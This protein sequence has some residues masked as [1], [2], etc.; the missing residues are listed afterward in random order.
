NE[1]L[2]QLVIHEFRHVAQ[3]QQATQGFSKL[4]YW[5][6]GENILSGLTYTLLPE[7]FWEGDAVTME[8]ALTSS[9]RGRIPAFNR[10]FLTNTLENKRF[11]YN[12]QYLGSFRDYVPNHYVLGNNLI[13]YVRSEE[14][15][16]DVWKRVVDRTVSRPF[17]PFTFSHALKKETGKGLNEYYNNMIDD[18]KEEEN[19]RVSNLITSTYSII[20]E[21][22]KTYTSFLYPSL[23]SSG[24][25]VYMKTGLSDIPVYEKDRFGK[26]NKLFTP[27]IINNT[28]MTY[29]D[30]DY[31]IWNEFTFHPR[32]RAESYSN[33]VV[34]DNNS[35]RVSKLSS[36][37]KYNGGASDVSHKRIV[38]TTTS[39]DY[40]HS[41]VL[42]DFITGEEIE[43]IP[44]PDNAFYS[45]VK[46]LDELHLVAVKITHKGKSLV[47][48]NLE[49]FNEIILIK[50][51]IENFG[52]PVPF[53]DYVFYTSDFSG[54]DNIYAIKLN[55]L[56]K[57]QVTS[58]KYGA[59]NP[60]PTD[61]V[62]L[63]NVQK[64][65]GVLVASMP[66]NPESWVPLRE[67]QVEKRHD[68]D[69]VLEQEGFDVTKT[70]ADSLDIQPVKYSKFKHLFN[71]HSWGPLATSSMDEVSLGIY[72]QDILSTTSLYAGY[73]YDV[74]E[75]NFR[76][77][78]KLSFQGMFP[79]FDLSFD[80]GNRKA[81]LAWTDTDD[82]NLY[83]N[84]TNVNGGFR[85]PLILT[86]SKFLTSLNT[87]WNLQHTSVSNFQNSIDGEG[88]LIDYNGDQYLLRSYIDNGYLLS[89][90]YK[91]SFVSALKTAHRQLKPRF[92]GI[93][94]FDYSH[95]VAGNFNGASMALRSQLYLPGIMKTHSLN[96][97]LAYQTREIDN[98]DLNNYYFRNKVPFPR[99]I[100]GVSYYQQFVS[101]GVN[102]E[103]PIVY[104]DLSLGPLL[105]VKRVRANLFFDGA[106]G[107]NEDNTGKPVTEYFNSTGIETR[108]DFN[109]VRFK[110]QITIGYRLSYGFGQ[111]YFHELIFPVVEF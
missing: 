49:S 42:L 10:M 72:S 1:W 19:Q 44:N 59:Y 38:T 84:E 95:D 7:W 2:D 81:Q 106:M 82:L 37:K 97:F 11:S 111:G 87:S 74:Y 57:F 91:I 30:K 39:E 83:W 18:I 5:L 55:T 88:R 53:K 25:L 43:H 63:F 105:Y 68:Y 24:N 94:I 12:K 85:I 6:L 50:E 73:N 109:T 16:A 31:I 51:G 23:D 104:P 70:I 14:K 47:K 110:P 21:T 93:F 28:G 100:K 101:T 90:N 3:Y 99:G 79:I 26:K 52:N 15:D 76:W 13:P 69:E 41:I 34:M 102:Y 66:F 27:G 60:F 61:S 45:H 40:R 4:T 46:F 36:N 75:N 64:K 20:S 71:I 67:V 65:E 103:F 58:V 89:S 62:L 77:E 56:D 54:I 92:G 80:T 9:G 78:G 107:I 8:T 17:V 33:I 108:M 29:Q 32:W 86:R 98:T 48:I 35:G 96:G 22:P